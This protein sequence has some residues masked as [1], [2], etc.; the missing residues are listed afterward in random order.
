MNLGR[1]DSRTLGAPHRALHLN[2][3]E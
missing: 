3:V 2:C 1:M